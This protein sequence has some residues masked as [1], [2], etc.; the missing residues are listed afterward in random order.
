MAG[1]LVFIGDSLTQWFDWQG[2]FPQYVVASL[3][4]SGETI[5]GL[6]ARLECIRSQVDNPDYIFIMSGINN[7]V[8]E[9]YRIVEPYREVVRNLTNWYKKSKVVIQSIL[10]VDVQWINNNIIIT[11]NLN[12][13]KMAVE[14]AS[15]YLDI[16]SAFV[17]SNGNPKKGYFSD[18]G[19]HLTNMG[20]LVWAYEIEKMLEKYVC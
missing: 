17:D 1:H 15:R 4:I 10:P 16:Y 2:R 14:F 6:L 19:V 20:Y 5:E 9:Q 12:L 7:I 8:N 3:G 18:D 13:E 11:T